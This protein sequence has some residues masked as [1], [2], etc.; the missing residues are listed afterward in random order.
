M[1]LFQQTLKLQRLVSKLQA[2][3]DAERRAN[4]KAQKQFKR[5]VRGLQEEIV[6]LEQDLQESQDRNN[7]GEGKLSATRRNLE[8]L[9]GQAMNDLL[10]RNKLETENKSLKAEIVDAQKKLDDYL[11]IKEQNHDLGNQ[12]Q[13]FEHKIKQYLA[14]VEDTAN[15]ANA[16]EEKVTVERAAKEA[17]ENRYKAKIA[18][19][20]LEI[21]GLKSH[22]EKLE[23]SVA[24]FQASVK[25]CW[26]HRFRAWKD[27]FRKRDR[28]GSWVSITDESAEDITLR[29]YS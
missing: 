15:K 27:R 14:I 7:V 28:S 16:N 2:D 26:W 25:T 11:S 29:T 17:M 12:V 8:Q 23:Q 4:T 24:R 20:D 6:N 18:E 3:L 5:D 10:A 19:Q 1:T 9:Q 21:T 13:S 22:S